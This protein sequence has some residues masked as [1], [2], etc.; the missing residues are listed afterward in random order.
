LDIYK[1]AVNEN[2]EEI[3]PGIDHSLR[4]AK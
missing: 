1:Q 2:A 3:Y 4:C